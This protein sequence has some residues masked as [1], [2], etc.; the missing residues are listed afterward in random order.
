[1]AELVAPDGTTYL[2]TE[3]IARGGFKSFGVGLTEDQKPVGVLTI[4]GRHGFDIFADDDLPGGFPDDLVLD[5]VNNITKFSDEFEIHKV[6]SID[7]MWF[8][9]VPLFDGGDLRKTLGA[10]DVHEREEALVRLLPDMIQQIILLHRKQ[11]AIHGDVK[12]ENFLLT[13]SGRV[14]LADFGLTKFLNVNKVIDN[15]LEGGTYF[16]PEQISQYRGT[17]AIDFWA[18][19]AS[20]GDAINFNASPKRPMKNPH[21]PAIKYGFLDAAE[22]R[23]K[24]FAFGEYRMGLFENQG[25]RE[26]IFNAHRLF[27]NVPDEREAVGRGLAVELP[28]Q[29][30]LDW[31]TS[32]Y[33]LFFKRAP[34]LASFCLEHLLEPNP[35][36]RAQ[37]PDELL[38]LATLMRA[39]LETMAGAS[40]GA[41]KTETVKF[42]Q[43]PAIA[44]AIASLHRAR[45][46][47]D[48]NRAAAA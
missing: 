38:G 28:E 17:P 26:G 25:G 15:S 8:L 42:P 24:L 35:A 18:L 5:E 4:R 37:N 16:A 39:S 7:N 43:D 9:V 14:V 21:V 33:R 27:L 1:V 19:G 48:R 30:Y 31:F 47:R 22:E 40:E 11:G 20:L 44:A 6:F 13:T 34:L 32:Y 29:R 10:I 12:L 23:K 3:P 36:I 2:V 46:S 45:Q 41:S